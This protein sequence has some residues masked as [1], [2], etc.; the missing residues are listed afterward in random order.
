MD[1]YIYSQIFWPLLNANT[2]AASTSAQIKSTHHYRTLDLGFWE[3]ILE[4]EGKGHVL[5][6]KGMEVTCCL[7]GLPALLS[8]RHQLSLGNCYNTINI[9][10]LTDIYKTLHPSEI[11]Y[12]HY[13]QGNIK[14]LAIWAIYWYIKQFSR[15]S[16]V[17]KSYRA[18]FLTTL[19]LN[20]KSIREICLQAK[21][22]W[23]KEEFKNRWVEEEIKKEI[24]S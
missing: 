16:K 22:T 7:H 19:D 21:R 17:W 3:V 11:E 15:N 8:L 24:R 5:E 4:A 1:I 20:Q 14:H 6:A 12:I 23:I 10:E 2:H 18:Y 13:F 9:L